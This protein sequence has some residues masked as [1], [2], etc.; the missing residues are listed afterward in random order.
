[1]NNMMSGQQNF[2]QPTNQMPLNANY[3][4]MLKSAMNGNMAGLS[5]LSTQDMQQMI[6]QMQMNGVNGLNGLNG[7][8][9][10]MQNKIQVT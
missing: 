3:L 7:N 2:V 4:D 6:M 1:M 5:G 10:Q 8:A 9:M